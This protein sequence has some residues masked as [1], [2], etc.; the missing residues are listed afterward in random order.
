MTLRFFL[1][2]ALVVFAAVTAAFGY[3]LHK[4]EQCCKP[5]A[6]IANG[7]RPADRLPSTRSAAATLSLGVDALPGDR[8]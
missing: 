3:R 7:D 8:P 2:I 4:D 5:L 6:P 1:V